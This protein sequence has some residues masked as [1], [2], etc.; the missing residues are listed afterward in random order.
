MKVYG[1]NILYRAKRK[2]YV[3]LA[4]PA[5]IAFAQGWHERMRQHCAR[6]FLSPL[7]PVGKLPRNRTVDEVACA[8]V[9][10]WMAAQTYIAQR[11]ERHKTLEENS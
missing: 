6:T 3:G 8:Y 4:N 5:Q 1:G 10:G 7:C 2:K 11:R 9:R